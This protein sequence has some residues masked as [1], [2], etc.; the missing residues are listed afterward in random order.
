MFKRITG[1]RNLGVEDIPTYYNEL[2][3]LEET[4]F[5]TKTV[6]DEKELAKLRGLY[7]YTYFL[8]P[9]TSPRKYVPFNLLVYLVTVAPPE[10]RKE[11]IQS[12]LAEYGYPLSCGGPGG[13]HHGAEGAG[14]ANLA[15]GNAGSDD[16]FLGGG[17]LPHFHS[18]LSSFGG[19]IT[20]Q[21][22]FGHEAL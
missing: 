21:R 6:T 16:Q 18:I 20:R 9:P 1:A 13:V 15:A 12:K 19:K 10:K 4:Y 5:G 14:L 3:Q 7:E 11:Y 17:N 2:N 8:H 22:E